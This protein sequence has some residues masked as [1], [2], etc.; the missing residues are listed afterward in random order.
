MARSPTK[1]PAPQ[2]PE[3]ARIP[4]PPLASKAAT[5]S[6]PAPKPSADV[7]ASPKAPPAAPAP[8][9]EAAPALSLADVK[10]LRDRLDAVK[11]GVAVAGSS[12]SDRLLA[13]MAAK[14][15]AARAE[16][17]AKIAALEARLAG[18]TTQLADLTAR[19]DSL[20]AQ[21]AAVGDD[22]DAE[23]RDALAVTDRLL[24]ELAR[25]RANGEAGAADLATA[26]T[27]LGRAQRE[28]ADL[29]TAAD[30]KSTGAAV[31]GPETVASLLNDFVGSF[32]SQLT[33][34][35]VASGEV[36]L[37]AGFAQLG[38]G[39]GFVLPTA[40]TPAAS[41]PVLHEI[42]LRLDTRS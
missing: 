3:P 34:L 13:A 16:D 5:P 39:A 26:K 11:P 19:A 18:L 35:D 24:A 31:L 41:L 8:P 17:R 4:A 27:S 32:K 36:S 9:V 14:L 40:G 15:D 10:L 12:P 30:P 6:G 1:P 29:R 20:A 22:R 21:A 7:A 23:L 2:K 42:T 37:K 33:G 25:S 28:V 38:K